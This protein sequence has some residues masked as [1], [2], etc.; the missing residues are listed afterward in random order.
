MRRSALPKIMP[1]WLYNS[2]F[3]VDYLIQCMA[4][5]QGKMYYSDKVMVAYRKHGTNTTTITNRKRRLE[6]GTFN[7]KNLAE[8]YQSVGAYKGAEFLR[9]ILPKRYMVL[10]YFYLDQGDFFNFLR[11]FFTGFIKQPLLK[12]R[13]HKDMVYIASPDLAQKLRRWVRLGRA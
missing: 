6:M 1:E 4:A 8:F 13:D 3:Q 7:V 2:G 9:S 10:G 11:Y 12:L 5:T